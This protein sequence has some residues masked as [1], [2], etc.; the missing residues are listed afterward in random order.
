M[1]SNDI[2]L[3]ES[4]QTLKFIYNWDAPKDLKLLI[5]STYIHIHFEWEIFKVSSSHFKIL[6][7]FYLYLKIMKG[8]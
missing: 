3:V 2:F 1:K 4:N 8:T 5:T 6:K 7:Y